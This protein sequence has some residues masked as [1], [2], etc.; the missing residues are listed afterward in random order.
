MNAPAL[1]D[2]GI[3]AGVPQATYR[4]WPAVSQSILKEFRRSPMHARH[5]MLFP[6][7]EAT[8]AMIFGEA[9]HVAILEPERFI[10]RYAVPPKVDKRTTAG[11][12]EWAFW[13]A[14]HPACVPL[15]ADEHE[16]CLA[17]ANAVGGHATAAKL[18]RGK[19]AN[20]VSAL[21]KDPGTGVVCKA[22][23]DRITQF[24][25][26]TVVVDVKTTRD[27]SLAGFS[28]A[29]AR[30]GYHMQAAHYLAGLDVIAPLSRRFIHIAVEPEP[31]HGVAIYE[32][33]EAALQQGR[34]EIRLAL[35]QYAD[36]LRDDVWPGYPVAVQPI[37]L[38]KWAQRLSL[39]EAA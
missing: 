24:D 20:E 30:Y 11:K 3:H 8:P 37:D 16:R 28:T 39:E 15:S 13:L 4:G 18:L 19:G 31:P 21:W 27:A 1:P 22:R 34:D 36:C 7:D 26:W 9:V 2:P 6:D 12:A 32:L 10:E 14:E 5:A 23:P 25:G 35:A 17:V 38:P 29:C 33:D